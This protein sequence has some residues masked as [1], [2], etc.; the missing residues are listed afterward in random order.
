MVIVPLTMYH[1]LK[2]VDLVNIYWRCLNRSENKT[3]IG[4]ADQNYHFVIKLLMQYD[5]NLIIVSDAK[6]KLVEKTKCLL[7]LKEAFMFIRS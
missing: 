1:D 6:Y 3:S 5:Y 4:D 2:D 7:G